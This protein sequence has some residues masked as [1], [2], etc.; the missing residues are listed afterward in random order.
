MAVED[1]ERG[2]E[3]TQSYLETDRFA[4]TPVRR[5]ALLAS[6][7]MRCDCLRC[8]SEISERCRGFRCRACGSGTVWLPGGDKCDGCGVEPSAD[9]VSGMENLEAKMRSRVDT[10][11]GEQGL[12]KTPGFRDLF[13]KNTESVF[14]IACCSRRPWSPRSQP[15][16]V[17]HSSSSAHCQFKRAA[18]P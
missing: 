17:S 15:R 7:W 2:E 9:A 10:I 16:F 8:A 6:K 1:I 13:M 4:P 18:S 3:L 5:D 12:S 11:D 14:I